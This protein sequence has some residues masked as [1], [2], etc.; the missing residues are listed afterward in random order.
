MAWPYLAF[1]FNHV[2]DSIIILGSCVCGSN[3]PGGGAVQ[4]DAAKLKKWLLEGFSIINEVFDKHGLPESE[5]EIFTRGLQE[6]VE[7]AGFHPA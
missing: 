5:K 1:F 6:V 7:Q 3:Y 4:I 2:D